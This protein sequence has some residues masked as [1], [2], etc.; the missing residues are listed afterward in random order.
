MPGHGLDP[1]ITNPDNLT[2]TYLQTVLSLAIGHWAGP[3]AIAI[4]LF[5][6]AAWYLGHRRAVGSAPT[7]LLSLAAL[8][9][10]TFLPTYH[11]EYDARLLLIAM[12]A[13]S[14]LA[15]RGFRWKWSALAIAMLSIFLTWHKW[16]MFLFHHVLSQN[17]A[18]LAIIMRPAAW[19]SLVLSVYFTAALWA[20]SRPRA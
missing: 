10:I 3:V 7:L 1:T 4:T 13:V 15:T 5:L 19:G 14:V 2:M 16:S 12:P 11:R 8:T 6:I 18:V 9:A 17:R 20:L